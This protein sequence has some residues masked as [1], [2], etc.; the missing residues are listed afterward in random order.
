M[1]GEE[2]LIELVTK[3]AACDEAKIIEIVMGAVQE[4]AGA[5]EQFDDMTILLARR[6]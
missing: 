2:R 4:W 1:F 5:V 6:T 3:N